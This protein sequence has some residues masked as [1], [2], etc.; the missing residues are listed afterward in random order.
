MM[1]QKEI[2]NH[3]PPFRS[4]AWEERVALRERKRLYKERLE[5]MPTQ[6][7]GVEVNNA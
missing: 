4:A 2:E 1:T 6:I 3:T 7:R 5:S